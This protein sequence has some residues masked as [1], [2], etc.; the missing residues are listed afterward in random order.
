M[1]NLPEIN[2]YEPFSSP[3]KFMNSQMFPEEKNLL[4]SFEDQYKIKHDIHNWVSVPASKNHKQIHQ[5]VNQQ[6]K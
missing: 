6:W 5:P 2:K 1:G 4:L 3:P